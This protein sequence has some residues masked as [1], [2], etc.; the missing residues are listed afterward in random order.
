MLA[1]LRSTGLQLLSA[2]GLLVLA[3]GVSA[4]TPAPKLENSR[5][6]STLD[7]G[8]KWETDAVVRQGMENIRQVMVARQPRIAKAELNAQDYRQLTETI[9]QHLAAVMQNRKISKGAEKA[10]HL[11]VMVDLTQ[12][13]NLM[14]TGATVPLQR[15]GA[16][17]VLQSLRLYGEFFQ[18]PGWAVGV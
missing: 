8:K 9:E 10:F 17:G 2:V 4:E 7:Q 5:I 16:L 15:V 11:V 1:V 13:L 6:E 3:C 14:R 12:N 18:H